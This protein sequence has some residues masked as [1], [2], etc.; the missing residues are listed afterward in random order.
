MAPRGDPCPLSSLIPEGRELLLD[1]PLDV[2]HLLQGHKQ[3]VNGQ[4]VP[5]PLAGPLRPDTHLRAGAVTQAAVRLERHVGRVDQ[6]LHFFCRLGAK[7]K[8]NY[9]V[10]VPVALQHVEVLV[11]AVGGGLRTEGL[12][13]PPDQAIVRAGLGDPRA[14]PI[15]VVSQ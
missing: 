6:A 2:H 3:A 5:G 4:R 10:G 8:R 1:E 15:P 7:H 11:G 13:L 9:G 12:G 14:E